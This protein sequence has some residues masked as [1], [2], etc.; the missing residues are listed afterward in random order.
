MAGQYVRGIVTEGRAGQVRVHLPDEDVI[1]PW[2]DVLA[3]TTKGA[4][5]Y[6]RPRVGSQVAVLLDA[7]AE[8]AVVVGALYSEVDPAPA[9]AED[10]YRRTFADGSTIAYEEASGTLSF[11]NAAGLTFT[12]QGTVLKVAG[13]VEIDG[14]LTVTG[15]TDLKDTRINGTRQTGS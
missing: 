7:N 14:D 10:V 3:P 8:T 5:A 4:T 13:D 15:E 12:V 6:Q 11:A 2:C 9:D 1:S